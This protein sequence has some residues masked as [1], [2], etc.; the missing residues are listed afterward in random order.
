M[1]LVRRSGE[2]GRKPRSRLK[3]RLYVAWLLLVC[4]GLVA[5]AGW[6]VQKEPAAAPAAQLL[7]TAWTI[8]GVSLWEPIL[9]EKFNSLREVLPLPQRGH[10]LG[11]IGLCADAGRAGHEG[12]AR[13]ARRCRKSPR[14]CAK[15]PT[16]ISTGS[17]ASSAC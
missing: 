5:A 6:M 7:P 13:H 1:R 3:S 14:P 10:R 15:G 8:G 9:G 2:A 17:S 4:V 12:P 16:P 11:R